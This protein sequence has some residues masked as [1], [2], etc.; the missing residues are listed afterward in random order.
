MVGVRRVD[1]SE[2]EIRPVPA[3]GCGDGREL[4]ERSLEV[5]DDLRRDHLRG[6]QILH[7]L[8]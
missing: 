7:V 2:L 8:Q 3:E 6:G 4:V 1:H 5:F